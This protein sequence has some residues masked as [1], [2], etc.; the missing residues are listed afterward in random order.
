MRRTQRWDTTRAAAFTLA[1]LL[2]VVAVIGILIS[3]TVPMV[4]RALG[5]ARTMGVMSNL[6]QIGLGAM[7]YV[8]DNEPVAILARRH[9][10]TE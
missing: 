4:A 10:E 3:I 1:E 8:Q 7:L 2:V 6:R 5:S 9:K